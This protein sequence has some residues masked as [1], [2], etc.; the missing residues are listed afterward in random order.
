M[1]I[2]MGTAYIA[3]AA[4][5][6]LR[7]CVLGARVDPVAVTPSDAPRAFG[8]KHTFME[9]EADSAFGVG[10]LSSSIVLIWSDSSKRPRSRSLR[11]IYG[12]HSRN[13]ATAPFFSGGRCF[14]GNW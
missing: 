4:S 7:P 8:P 5:L 6:R 2:G 10:T 12:L 11:L 3:D 1:Q 13:F 14:H 9:A